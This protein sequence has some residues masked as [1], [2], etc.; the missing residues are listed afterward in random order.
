[1]LFLF[2]LFCTTKQKQKT[3]PHL[4]LLAQKQKWKAFA[5]EME[6]FQKKLAKKGVAALEVYTAKVEGPLEDWLAEI[7]LPP[8]KEL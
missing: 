2:V 7:E 8:S 4:L 3:N 5:K 6:G 1:M